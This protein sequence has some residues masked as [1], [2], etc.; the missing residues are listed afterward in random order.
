MSPDHRCEH[1]LL[2]IVPIVPVRAEG[3]YR[4]RCLL[5]EVVGPLKDNEG[6]ARQALL[7][8]GTRNEVYP[9]L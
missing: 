9:S 2:G 5:C 8:H 7:E 6:N 1:K 3:G 4:G